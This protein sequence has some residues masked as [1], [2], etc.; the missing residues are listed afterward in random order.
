LQAP[1]DE[2]ARYFNAAVILSGPMVALSSNSPFLF[3]RS[4]WEETRVPL[5][6]QAVD[7]GDDAHPER[8]RVTFGS[9]YLQDTVLE[10]YREN[11][12]RF[13]VLLPIA[14][15][16]GPERLRHLRLHNGTIW[17]WNRLLVGCE[18]AHPPHLRI[19]HRVMP[20]GP[21]I[22]DMIANAAV[23]LGASRFLAG[24]RVAPESDLSFTDARENFYS[25]AREGMEARLVW[26][27]GAQVPVP[28]L[29]LQ[30]LLPMAREGLKLFGA[31]EED[32]D[33][34]LGVT[35]NRVRTGQNGAVW[36]RAHVEKY[37]RDFFRLTAD[38]LE[39]QRSAMP[40]HEWD[41]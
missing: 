7:V 18:E 17:R 11:V 1:A 40:V 34:Y 28:D 15:D 33:R 5:F 20:A 38:Y 2:A 27:D 31:D 21:T 12:E 36:Q 24:L 37:G 22:V 41:L 32:I 10:C 13:P 9:G 26:L 25:A 16:N 8:R 19:E 30:E 39:H 29:L 35:E 3:E 6:E 4:L 14:F 23:Y